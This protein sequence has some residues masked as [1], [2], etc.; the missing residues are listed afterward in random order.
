M[1]NVLNELF[2]ENCFAIVGLS[3]NILSF[4]S[5]LR[6]LSSISKNYVHGTF[7]CCTKYFCQL[8][9]V[10]ALNN[11]YFLLPNKKFE[12]YQN[13]FNGLIEQCNTFN[14]NFKRDVIFVDFE[15]SIYKAIRLTWPLAAIKGCRFHL[16]Q[17]WWRKI[18]SLGLSTD[19][20][21]KESDI[22]KFLTY[23]FGLPFLE[24]G[25]V[26]ECFAIDLVLIQPST[27]QI[28]KF[29]DYLV[30]TYID[31]DSDFPPEIWATCSS[32]II[33][34]F[35]EILKQCQTD[36]KIEMQSIV[37]TPREKI[38]QINK[39]KI[40][41]NSNHKIKKLKN[42]EI[43]N[44]DFVYRRSSYYNKSLNFKL[45]YVQY[46]LIQYFVNQC[47]FGRNRDTY[48]WNKIRLDTCIWAAIRQLRA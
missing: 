25:I 6:N 38:K 30:E 42:L 41:I 15:T 23:I 32:S 45:K 12:S 35:L 48:I 7:R 16:D 4:E 47:V 18:Q 13:A 33:F 14:F 19:Y 2:N 39:K 1:K 22:G 40:H 26:G 27:A 34:Q 31:D 10:H 17:S 44:F 8:F 9:T 43:S 3:Q 29:Y 36:A 24:P 11:A 37:C 20:K 5:N 46:T 21:D 28:Q